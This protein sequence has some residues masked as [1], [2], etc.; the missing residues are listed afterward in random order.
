M[1]L[2]LN[3]YEGRKVAKT[4]TAE[5]VDLS[6]GVIEDVLDALDFESMRSGDKVELA[7][8]I[9]K[10]K[11]QIKPF[12]MDIFDGLTAEEV[13]HTRTGNLVEVFRGLYEYAVGELG[14][15][16]SKN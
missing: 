2:K 12:L 7:G 10:C 13:R 5:S 4:Y 9:V 15:V 16:G 8:M 14:A 3:I 1:E 6:F 11:D